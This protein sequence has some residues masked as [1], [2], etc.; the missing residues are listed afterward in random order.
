MKDSG[1][2]WLGEVPEHWEMKPLKHLCS[3]LRDGTHLPPPRVCEGIPLLSVR[4][5]QGEQ[6]A[7]RE[8]DSLISPDD[9]QEL[10]RSFTPLPGDVLLAIVGATMGK[11]AL[12]PDC[13]GDFHIQRSLAVFRARPSTLC[14]EWLLFTFRSIGFQSLLWRDVSFSAQPGIYLGALKD[15]SIPTPPIKEQTE[16]VESCRERLEYLRDVIDVALKAVEVQSERRSA[17]ISAAVTGQ[18]DVRGLVPEQAEQ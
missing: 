3:L 7:I 16:I 5:I 13:L 10:C 6:F 15:M 8:D 11:T 4:N 18:I 2:E 1:V 17:L 12:V 9:Y 14:P